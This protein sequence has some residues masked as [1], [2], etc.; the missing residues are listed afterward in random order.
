MKSEE[1]LGSE[2]SGGVGGGS[3][4]GLWGIDLGERLSTVSSSLA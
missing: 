1:S 4:S 2:G 3:G